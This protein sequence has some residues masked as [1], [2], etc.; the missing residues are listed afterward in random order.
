MNDVTDILP[1]AEP[2]RDI[3]DQTVWHGLISEC[4]CSHI[5]EDVFSR[6]AASCEAIMFTFFNKLGMGNNFLKSKED[7]KMHEHQ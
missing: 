1:V 6:E 5:P 3:F 4:R 7:D 2:H